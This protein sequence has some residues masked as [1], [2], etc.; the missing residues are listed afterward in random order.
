[1]GDMSGPTDDWVAQPAHQ[2][3]FTPPPSKLATP[4]VA[5][6]P[7]K[8]QWMPSMVSPH[9]RQKMPRTLSSPTPP[10]ETMGS[11]EMPALP[12]PAHS[13]D[14]QVCLSGECE[15]DGWMDKFVDPEN[16][17]REMECTPSWVADFHADPSRG[18][19]HCPPP[20]DRAF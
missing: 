13:N 20:P 6:S 18:H 8:L 19:C 16:I 12:S 1:M 9:K 10:T 3:V 7:K 2:R 5:M 15:P 14:P 11:F 4:P 17:Q